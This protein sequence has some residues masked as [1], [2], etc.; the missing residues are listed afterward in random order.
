M[1][2]FSVLFVCRANLC[3]SPTAHAVL[4]KKSCA[5]GMESWVSVD[6]AS[7]HDHYPSGPPDPRSQQHAASR[8]YD[9]SDLRSRPIQPADFEKADLIL[10]MDLDNLR[11]LQ[12][13]CPAQHAGKLRL[14]TDFCVVRRSEVVPDPYFGVHQDFEHVLDL[15]E[16]ACDGLLQ[17]VR[18]RRNDP[19]R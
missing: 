10:V 1:E 5:Q 18:T 14:L 16:D 15:V 3:R 13:A 8:G 19:A 11:V 6:S 12:E 4:R 17:H 2:T 9:L 7:T